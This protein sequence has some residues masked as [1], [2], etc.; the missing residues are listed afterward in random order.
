ML[1]LTRSLSDA[2]SLAKLEET[3]HDLLKTKISSSSLHLSKAKDYSKVRNENF[4]LEGI[5]GVYEAAGKNRELESNESR[6]V[7][8]K[9][10]VNCEDGKG[11][12]SE[13]SGVV[14]NN[15][16][17]HNH[18]EEGIG[19]KEVRVL[20]DFDYG[21]SGKNMICSNRNKEVMDVVNE[22]QGS[23]KEG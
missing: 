23:V 5:D 1:V 14:D 20:V 9:G 22:F 8:V 18:G 13:S 3:I 16:D 10:V 12:G 7:D 4:G 19:N 15:I 2:Y 17:F 6:I 11:H 21:E